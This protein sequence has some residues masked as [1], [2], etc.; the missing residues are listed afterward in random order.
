MVRANTAHDSDTQ[1]TQAQI[2]AWLDQAYHRLRKLIASVAPSLY[3]KVSA[4]QVL[5]TSDPNFDLPS[6]YDR[7]LLFEKLETTVWVGVDTVD[8]TSPDLTIGRG[9]EEIGAGLTGGVI[10]VSPASQAD[11]SFRLTYVA[12][13]DLTENGGNYTLRVPAGLEELITEAVSARARTRLNEDKDIHLTEVDRLWA[14]QRTGIRRR[15]GRH[16]VSGMRYTRGE[17]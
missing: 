5:S 7:P 15:Y 9:W 11:G 3:S 4:T 17:P 1:V 2:Q 13:P 10:R 6:D 14:Q 8:Q 16:A 12:L